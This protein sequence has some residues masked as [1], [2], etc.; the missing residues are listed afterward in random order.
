MYHNYESK[1][2]SIPRICEKQH[3][4]SD[5]LYFVNLYLQQIPFFKDLP[6]IVTE[7][8]LANITTHYYK[9]GELVHSGGVPAFLG[10]VFV[11][12]VQCR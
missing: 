10:V 9:A 5:E 7:I 12:S 3:R 2:M 8:I 6:P 1:L 11:G 4:A